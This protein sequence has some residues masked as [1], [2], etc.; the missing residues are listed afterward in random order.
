M[1]RL[2]WVKKIFPMRDAIDMYLGDFYRKA[3]MFTIDMT[4]NKTKKCYVSPLFTS[5]NESFFDI[6]SIENPGSGFNFGQ[7]LRYKITATHSHN[8]KKG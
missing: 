8:V 3:K 4:Y 2:D 5:G 7:Q 1:F 6:N